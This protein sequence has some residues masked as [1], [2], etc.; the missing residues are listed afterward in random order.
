MKLTGII[1]LAF[2]AAVSG[3]DYL[4]TVDKCFEG[5][6]KQESLVKN[7]DYYREG[8]E[9]CQRQLKYKEVFCQTT[10]QFLELDVIECTKNSDICRMITNPPREFI[11]SLTAVSDHDDTPA[12]QHIAEKYSAARNSV[13]PPKT[14][15]DVANIIFENVE[16]RLKSCSVNESTLIIPNVLNFNIQ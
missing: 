5:L 14:T 10:C 11:M 16:E 9:Y 6:N 2:M 3:F 1:L 15:G 8:A 12:P 13:E 4:A 7:L